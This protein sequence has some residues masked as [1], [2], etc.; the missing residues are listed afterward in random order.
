MVGILCVVVLVVLMWVGVL[1]RRVQKQTKI[2]RQQLQTEAAL[3]ERYEDLVENANDM[4]LPRIS[5]IR[6]TRQC[7]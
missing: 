3:K 4:V 6:F 2:I 1:R 5:Q 7:Y